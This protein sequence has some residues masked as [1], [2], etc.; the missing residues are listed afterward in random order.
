MSDLE[1]NLLPP[2]ASNLPLHSLKQSSKSGA[3]FPESQSISKIASLPLSDAKL[4]L[5]RDYGL[6]IE[7][8]T[9]H[10]SSLSIT[11]DNRYIIWCSFLDSNVKI[12]NFEESRQVEILQGHTS[13]V[14]CVAVTSDSRYIVSGSYD[15]TL[16]IWDIARRTQIECLLGHDGAVT[17]VVITRDNH[18]IISSAQDDT[19]RTWRLLGGRKDE[20]ATLIISSLTKSIAVASSNRH[21]IG[22]YDSTVEIWDF[23]IPRIKCNFSDDSTVRLRCVK[24]TNDDSHMITGSEDM[25]FKYRVKY[26]ICKSIFDFKR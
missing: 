20:R 2:P 15:T 12:W 25:T 3:P 11:S 26:I 8:Y 16:R 14:S 17:C 13:Y 24:V 18:Y 19:I 1:Q 21:I 6:C 4:L 10:V 23:K 7:A 9:D 5:S 22:I